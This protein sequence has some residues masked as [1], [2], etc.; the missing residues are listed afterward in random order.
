[1]R[2]SRRSRRPHR[3]DAGRTRRPT[4]SSVSF[5]SYLTSF[6]NSSKVICLQM[7]KV[8]RNLQLS[9]LSKST[10]ARANRVWQIPYQIC[11]VL[12]YSLSNLTNAARK[13]GISA[14]ELLNVNPDQKVGLHT[15]L[16]C[17]VFSQPPTRSRG[18]F[19]VKD[20]SAN[21]PRPLPQ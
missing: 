17:L 6:D 13:V 7:P 20:K 10:R 5:Q 12:T 3:A 8:S 16:L 21:V 4:P 19:P 9:H 14:A 1:M 11:W 15:P 18:S 2:T